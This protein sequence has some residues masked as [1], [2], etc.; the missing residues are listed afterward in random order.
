MSSPFLKTLLSL[1]GIDLIEVLA[2]FFRLM[3]R[4]IPL[5]AQ[6]GIYE[7]LERDIKLELRDIEGREA[8]FFKRQRVRFLQDNIIAYEDK[9]WGDG[10]IFTDYKCSPGV[11]V[12]RYREGHRYRILISLRKTENRGDIEEFH[13]QR[14]IKNGFRQK[15][16]DLQTEI[17]HRTSKMSL[18]VVFPRRRPPKQM[19]L[20]EQKA[21][22]STVLDHQHLHTLPDGRQEVVWSTDKP[23]LFEAYILRWEW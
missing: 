16:E 15:T 6:P 3:Q 1:L 18:S 21:N 20:I 7:V 22:R 9:A 19:T 12:D 23:R 17:D 13:I 4:I 5:Q 11:I 10:D 8:V 14:T 2:V